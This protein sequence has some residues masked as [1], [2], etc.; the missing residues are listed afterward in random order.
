[1]GYVVGLIKQS[2]KGR[3]M[4]KRALMT[5]VSL[6]FTGCSTISSSYHY[7]SGTQCLERG[8]YAGAIVEL[9]QAVELDPEMARNHSNLSYAYLCNQEL[10]KA[11]YHSRQA[12][13][14]PYKDDAGYGNFSNI[15]KLMIIDPKLNEP[16][17]PIEEIRTKLGEPDIEMDNGS[18]ITYLYGCCAMEFKEGK[19]VKCTVP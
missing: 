2:H 3:A 17:T 4:V 11:W 13:L 8:D 19:L 9:E 16:G 14:C 18:M 12:V 5:L 15:C 7:T 10:D 6:V 1:M